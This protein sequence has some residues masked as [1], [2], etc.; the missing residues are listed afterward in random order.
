LK[1]EFTSCC[2]PHGRDASDRAP[3]TASPFATGQNSIRSPEGSS[4]IREDAFDAVD[5][6]SNAGSVVMAGNAVLDAATWQALLK[7]VAEAVDADLW[8]RRN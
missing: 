1:G 8:R 4:S 7:M 6:L 3:E 2:K 5:Q